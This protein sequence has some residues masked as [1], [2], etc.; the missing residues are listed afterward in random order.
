MSISLKLTY[1]KQKFFDNN[2]NSDKFICAVVY[3]KYNSS[4]IEVVV[5]DSNIDKISA[6]LTFDSWMDTKII[7]GNILVD[8]QPDI[9]SSKTLPQLLEKK[10]CFMHKLH[11]TNFFYRADFVAKLKNDLSKNSVETINLL[12][13]TMDSYN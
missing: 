4:E 10:G 11:K 7:G 3:I 13:T 12:E 1:K 2:R 9:L 6:T 8:L 5:F